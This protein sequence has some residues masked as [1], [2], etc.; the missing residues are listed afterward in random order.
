MFRDIRSTQNRPRFEVTMIYHDVILRR[1][2][3]YNNGVK[4]F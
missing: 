4:V 2:R 1:I 3:S